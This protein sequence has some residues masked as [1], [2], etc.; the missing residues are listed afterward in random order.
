MM[1]CTICY[2]ELIEDLVVLTCGHVYH[3]ECL[4]EWRMQGFDDPRTSTCP[5]C[6][7]LID[8]LGVHP[9]YLPANRVITKF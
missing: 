1:D 3:A 9:V 5:D 2:S 8:I 6:R 4:T 7:I